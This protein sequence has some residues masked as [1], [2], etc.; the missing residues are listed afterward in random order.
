MDDFNEVMLSQDVMQ[1]NTM[2][3]AKELAF[4]PTTIPE[5]MT[6]PTMFLTM[7]DLFHKA[8]YAGEDLMMRAKQATDFSMTDYR[9]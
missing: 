9:Q 2:R 1:S 7:V 6:R 4:W 5:K 3:K 8:G